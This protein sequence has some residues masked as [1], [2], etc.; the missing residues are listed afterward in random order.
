MRTDLAGQVGVQFGARGLIDMEP[1]DRS[2]NIR[3]ACCN[4]QPTFLAQRNFS[5]PVYSYM[6]VYIYAA[7]ML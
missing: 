4:L 5:L 2:G 6:P 3:E 1:N 7:Y